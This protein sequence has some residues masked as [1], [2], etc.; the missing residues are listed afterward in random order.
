[1]IG[2]L[3]L[4][5]L[6]LTCL[7]SVTQRF[8]FGVVEGDFALSLSLYHGLELLQQ[9]GLRSLYNFLHGIVV[10]DKGYGRTRAELQRDSRFT[11]L[12][13]ALCA[14]FQPIRYQYTETV[15]LVLVVLCVLIW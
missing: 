2:V 13:D 10:G 12:M 6:H 9:H 15:S 8:T 14:K 1:M 7:T 3:T 11:E 4:F 5:H